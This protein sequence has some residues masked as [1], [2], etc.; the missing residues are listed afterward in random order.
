MESGVNSSLHE[1]CHH[2]RTYGKFNRKIYYPLP[3]ER[4]VCHYQNTNTENIKKAIS[5][6]Q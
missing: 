3:Y 1:N 4:E 2:Q 5:E 6:F